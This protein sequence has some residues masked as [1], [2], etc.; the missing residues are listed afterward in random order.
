MKYVG[1][2][3]VFGAAWAAIQYSQGDVT[4]IAAL[5]GP[6]LL[7]GAFGGVLWLARTVYLKITNQR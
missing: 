6:V 3:L 1:V 2:G 5:A 4:N 7:C